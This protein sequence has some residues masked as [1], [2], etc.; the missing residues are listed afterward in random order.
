MPYGNEGFMHFD[1]EGEREDMKEFRDKLAFAG[2]D[3]LIGK[4]VITVIT[5]SLKQESTMFEI[6]EDIAVGWVK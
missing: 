6:S 4:R 3:S 5:T 1:F 2:I